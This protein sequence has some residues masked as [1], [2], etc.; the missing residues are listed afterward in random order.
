MMNSNGRDWNAV[1][2]RAESKKG[3]VESY[4][5]KL[6]DPEERRALWLKAT[7][8]AR[9]GERAVAEAWAIAFHRGDRPVGVKQVVPWQEAHFSDSSFDV[10]V[11]DL[12]MEQGRTRGSIEHEGRRVGWDLEFSCDEAPL[13]P[14]PLARMY[15]ASFPKSK[16]V[17]PNPDSRFRG[18]YTVDGERVEVSEWR[19]MQGHNWGRGHAD[20]YAWVH[21][22]QWN[23]AE[24]LMFEGV[25]ARVRVGPVLAPPITLLCLRHRGVRYELNGALDLARARG[26]ITPRSYRFH[27]RGKHAR[28]EGEVFA[29]TED[30]G[31]LYY[32]NPDGAMTHCLNSKIAEGRLRLELDGRPPLE[33]TTRSA[34]LEIGTRHPG[35]GVTMLV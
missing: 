31:G 28:V 29:A 3:H 17:S 18:H 14:F 25:T 30:F 21:C 19:G 27:A 23:G 35:H 6:N 2:Y 5:I 11:A 1:R 12:A 7:I 33:V 34:A 26:E 15:E 22:N 24:E 20:S 9:A 10:Q 4:F 8:L 13:I 16:L 32:E